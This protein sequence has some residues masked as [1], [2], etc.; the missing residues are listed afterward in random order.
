MSYYHWNW[1]LVWQ[2]TQFQIIQWLDEF[3]KHTQYIAFQSK[4]NHPRPGYKDTHF[5]CRDF[6]PGPGPALDNWRPCWLCSRA[7]PVA[8]I[9]GFVPRKIFEILVCCR[10]FLENFS[11]P[12]LLCKLVCFTGGSGLWRALYHQINWRPP[13]I[14]GPVR[15]NTRTCLT[16]ALSWNNELSLRIWTEIYE[17]VPA[18]IPKI[19]FSCQRFRKKI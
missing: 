10:W 12:S 11:T 6:D 1:P 18:C 16:P 8:G 15:P 7:N 5:G 14:G 3:K 19:N 13:K 17:D 2:V 9:L 4:A